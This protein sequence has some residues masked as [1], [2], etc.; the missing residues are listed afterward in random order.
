MFVLIVKLHLYL[1]HLLEYL[2]HQINQQKFCCFFES[3]HSDLQAEMEG[4]N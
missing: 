1:L 3:A 2:I 4:S